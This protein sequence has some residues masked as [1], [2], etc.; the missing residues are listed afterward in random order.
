MTFT[1]MLQTSKAARAGKS[2]LIKKMN[3]V[4]KD[5][6]KEI[7]D[8]QGMTI[9]EWCH[10]TKEMPPVEYQGLSFKLGMHE[11][12]ELTA[13]WSQNP[14]KDYQE[15]WINAY[16]SFSENQFMKFIKEYIA[17]AYCS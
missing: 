2:N 4:V 14:T 17:N 8:N 6:Q 5:V 13:K 11:V 7:S 12:V 10:Y 9:P 16:N 15:K 1:E 3:K